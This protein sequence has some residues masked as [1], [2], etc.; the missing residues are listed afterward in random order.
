MLGVGDENHAKLLEF[1][2]DERSKQL[3][4]QAVQRFS[5]LGDWMRFN[6]GRPLNPSIFSR[7]DWRTSIDAFRRYTYS[8]AIRSHASNQIRPRKP[9][10]L[11]RLT[12]KN[13]P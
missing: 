8:P 2:F 10:A 4:K 6:P 13:N 5:F 9:N 11:P 7:K 1:V 12:K 3:R